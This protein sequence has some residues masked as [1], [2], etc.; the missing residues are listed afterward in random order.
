MPL[1]MT[2]SSA[3]RQAD[4]SRT[5]HLSCSAGGIVVMCRRFVSNRARPPAT[6]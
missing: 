5:L 2:H 3:P 1:R 4:T 6:A